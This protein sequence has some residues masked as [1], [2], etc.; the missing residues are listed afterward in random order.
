MGKRKKYSVRKTTPTEKD[1][2]S[3]VFFIILVV[4]AIAV[5][6]I[7]S[8]PDFKI[9]IFN[10]SVVVTQPYNYVL[11]KLAIA[12]FLLI[13]LFI[14][15][16]YHTLERKEILIY[17]DPAYL[18]LVFFLGWNVLSL[19]FSSFRYASVE[20]IGKLLTY[21]FLY[22][23]VVNW[24]KKRENFIVMVFFILIVGAVLSLHGLF[25]YLKE[26]TPVIISTFGNQNYFSA[27]LILLLPLVILTGIYNWGRQ[28]F[29]FSSLIF[30]LAYIV[31]FLIRI[32][33]SQGAFL[34]IGAS[35]LFLIIL[36]R[37]QIFNPKIRIP[38]LA[39]LFALLLLGSV[40]FFQKL[41]QIKTYVDNEIERGTVGIRLKIWQG[42]LRMIKA[43]PLMGW[44]T[45]TFYLVYP[46]FRVPEYFLN[47][48]SVN[49][50]RH[51]H[52][53]LLEITA[54][55]GIIGVGLFLWL[56]ATV[57]SKGIKTFYKKPLNLTNFLNAG[58]LAGV[59]ALV[60]QNLTGV[61]FRF[62]ASALYFYLFIGL[63]SAECNLSEERKEGDFFSKKFLK[64][65]ALAW[66][67]I[68]IAIL[69]GVIY[70]RG[71][72]SS[73]MSDIYLKRGLVF[74]YKEKWKEAT[75]EYY[76]SIH[77]NPYN[78]RTYYRLAFAY[79]MMGKINESLFT[80]LK[81]KKLAPDYAQIHINL[82]GLYLQTGELKNAEEELKRAIELNPYEASTHNT[83]G[84]LYLKTGRLEDAKKELQKSI[85][86]DPYEPRTHYNL[87]IVYLQLKK[88]DNA[89]VE[90]KQAI[91]VQEEKKKINPNL[92]DFRGG[93]TGL[94]DIYY[95]QE[96]WEEA[97]QNYERAVQLDEKNVKILLRLGNC[98]LSLKEPKKA[99]R[100]Y[101][102]ALKQDS[103]LI[104]V[105]EIIKQ[106]DK[107]IESDKDVEDVSE[108]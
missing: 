58:L 3:L 53:E 51:A 52:N 86:L 87:A 76:K 39:G 37:R 16:F 27:Y 33:D 80:Y 65:K 107:I 84:G 50:T 34:G 26:R 44:G 25:Y 82:G 78:Q 45:G 14:I 104:Q 66:F 31:I 105:E 11:V 6:A 108:E 98:Y 77:W 38:I 99:K 7:M 17:K 30:I 46:N 8:P 90:F 97:S 29:F 63:I 75:E 28:N 19:F 55:T 106:L 103:S 1:K 92:A 35:L 71:T 40:L 101:E 67:M 2:R 48:H 36:F 74:R 79:G 49:A 56:L 93:Y 70:T 64:K 22:F 10:W 24:V 85:E 73:I 18:P 81:L 41:P 72:L 102:E 100:T 42:S 88:T 89:I 69:L 43:R 20:E 32:M 68:L 13:V 9:K 4:I 54:E 5:P 21:A 23:A 83:L 60:T 91:S 15:W 94:G 62:S 96:N 95:S 59:V 47:P 57:F 61:N 12:Q